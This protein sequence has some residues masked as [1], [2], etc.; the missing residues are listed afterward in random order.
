MNHSL[1]INYSLSSSEIEDSYYIR[2]EQVGIE[3]TA[4]LGEVASLVD[5]LYE[6]NPCVE[7][8]DEEQESVTEEDA[9]TAQDDTEPESVLDLVTLSDSVKRLFGMS[10]CEQDAAGNWYAQVKVIRSHV[11]EPY[12]L[13]FVGGEEIQTVT[14]EELID[15]VIPLENVSGITLE[16]P[17]V[18]DF[19]AG[20]NGSAVGES[21]VQSG[22]GITRTGNTLN[23]GLSLSGSIRVQ[24]QTRYDLIDVLVYGNDDFSLGECKVI[25]FFHGLVDELDLEQPEQEGADEDR[26]DYCDETGSSRFG[27]VIS[28]EPLPIFYIT[29][30]RYYCKCSGDYAYSIYSSDP[31]DDFYGRIWNKSVRGDYVDCNEHTAGYLENRDFYIEACCTTPEAAEVSLPRCK[32][33]RRKNKGGQKISDEDLQWYKDKYGSDLVVT[34]ISPTD[35]DCGDTTY[36][37]SVDTKNCCDEVEPM[38]WDPDF[39]PTVIPGL[40]HIIGGRAPFDIHVEG[41]G[42]SLSPYEEDHHII[43][44]DGWFRIYDL[45]A[46]G[47]GEILITDA[48][49]QELTKGIR[50][51]D[52]SWLKYDNPALPGPTSGCA[53]TKPS[54]CC[55]SLFMCQIANPE[56]WTRSQCESYYSG[57]IGRVANYQPEDETENGEWKIVR[58]SC[59]SGRYCYSNPC[60]KGGDCTLTDPVSGLSFNPLLAS[61]CNSGYADIITNQRYKWVC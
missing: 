46:C 10:L 14:T 3:E 55:F 33:V 61:P 11:N 34:Y 48:C 43:D 5:D 13:K 41:E 42:F 59:W 50:S 45:G 37:Q 25:A 23:W 58:E 16:Y 18:S 40:Y 30:T 56:D 21:G 38:S 27:G 4:T 51:A 1:T 32:E 39:S 7:A 24:Y 2:L 35:G 44:Y 53:Y 47:G 57:G 6:I 19:I 15:E 52:G 20:W 54:G 60:Y 9:V 12:A 28:Q 26:E 31:P 17:V 49:D 8:E 22:P 29:E 36:Y